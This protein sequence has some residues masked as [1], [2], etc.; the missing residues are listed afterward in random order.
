[1]SASSITTRGIIKKLMEKGHEIT[2]L[3][4]KRCSEQA[5]ICSSMRFENNS[6]VTIV[7]TPTFV[8]SY[9]I[10]K[11]RRMRTL[12]LSV[13]HIFLVLKG[14]KV[15]K[16]KRYDL[17]ISQ[18]HSS[19]FASLSALLLSQVFKLPLIVRTHD[20]YDLASGFFE[21]LYLRLLDKIYRAVLRLAD[22][23]C[24]VSNPLRLMVVQT[25][26]LR[27]DKVLVFPNAVDIKTFRPNMNASSLRRALG[28]EGR[29]ILLFAGRITEERGLALL[30]KALPKIVAEKS[31][32]MVLVVGEGSQKSYLERLAME[33]RVEEFVR[34]IQPVSH[35]KMPKFISLSEV[36][37]G[38]LVATL[39]TLGSVPRKVLEYMACAKPVVVCR[40]GVSSDLIIQGYNGFLIPPEDTDELASVILKLVNNSDLA[41]E[42]GSNARE[43]VEQF[44]DW[45]K[46]MD[47]FD[48]VL[49]RLPLAKD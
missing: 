44:Y 35:I 10:D 34:F 38:P 31:D 21:S 25:H 3:V 43:Y 49:Q 15:C 47:E 39:D 30:I 16:Q 48:G 14:L 19:H 26:K 7:R 6:K 11:S 41:K 33:L 9:L 5:L 46:L 28:V 2:L 24:V 37:V 40:G 36:T 42:I 22:Y 20:I 17:I 8:S 32:V 18:H 45:D 29:K 4:P 23:V 13:S 27:E 12:V 1:M